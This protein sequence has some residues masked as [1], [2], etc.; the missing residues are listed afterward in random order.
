M[1]PSPQ[2]AEAGSSSYSSNTLH[3]GDGTWDS[4]R[5]TFLLPNL[6]T[7]NFATMQYN[8]MGN[9]FRELTEYHALIKGHGV[10]AAITFL[11]VVPAAVMIARF[12]RP[13]PRMAMRMHIH[14]QI[15]TLFLVTIIFMLGWFAV[16]PERSLTNPHHD[17]GL[18]IYVLIWFQILWGWFVYRREKGKVR[19][20]A[21]IR[22]MLHQWLGRATALLALAQIGSGLYLYGSPRSLFILYG[23]ALGLLILLY[24]AFSY[25]NQPVIGGD[26]GS[27]YSGTDMTPPRREKSR[28]TGLK[29]MAGALGGAALIEGFRRNRRSRD[30][31]RRTD[32]VSSRP[33]SRHGSRSRHSSRHRPSG[34]YTEEDKYSE[35]DTRHQHTWRNRILGGVAAGGTIAGLRHWMNRRRGQDL[36]SDVS[37]YTRPPGGH[38]FV[39]HDDVS[40]VNAGLPPESPARVHGVRPGGPAPMPGR[41]PSR[42]GFRRAG[43]SVSSYTSINHGEEPFSPEPESPEREHHHGVRD[44]VAALGVAGFARHL[45]NR[46]RQNREDQ[47]VDDMRRQD[48]VQEE[49]ARRNSRRRQGTQLTGDGSPSFRRPGLNRP[50]AGGSV[51]TLDDTALTGSNPAL[52]RQ[53]LPRPGSMPG[54]SHSALAPGTTMSSIT[55]THPPPSNIPLPPP[56]GGPAMPMPPPPIQ[57]P[58]YVESGS[59]G[60]MSPG[61]HQHRRHRLRDAAE[62]GASSAA[63]DH[64]YSR[65]DGVESPPVSV[66]VKM[67]N[68]GRHVTLRRL[69]EEEAAAEREA[70]RRDPRRRNESMGSF[71]GKE[72]WRR[73]ERM[74][75]AQ[76]AQMGGGGPSTVPPPPAP[77]GAP[78][79]MPMASDHLPGPAYAQQQ[80]YQ[81]PVEL[82]PPPPPPI[83]GSGMGAAASP[84]SVGAYGTETDVSTYDN[85]RRRRRAERTK[86]KAAAQ[87]GRVEFE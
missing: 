14:L 57:D 3:V 10:L 79:A 33:G 68:D 85:N 66:K 54:A 86:A 16:G 87:T 31:E 24:F 11:G 50:A 13:N 45:W 61:G 1:S 6:Q 5:D 15:L 25:A 44:G 39:T 80:Q 17:I 70:R 53:H 38:T 40:R 49:I 84:P 32:V 29:T 22:L 58:A 52:S 73:N 8:G 60:Y 12:Y 46:R 59:E 34:S 74:E 4:S 27:Y 9:R 75:A 2:L 48:R 51:V 63:A 69:N 78:V 83:P 55:P 47:R 82:P 7:L 62:A 30:E 67:H 28:H 64:L 41:T 26:D 20:K 37:S 71:D 23:L 18:T 72:R 36:E 35:D 56:P 65:N 21:P 81:Q 76:A 42:P 43:D 77:G 19:Y